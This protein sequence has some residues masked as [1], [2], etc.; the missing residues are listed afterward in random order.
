M[1]GCTNKG[2]HA[3]LNAIRTNAS[4]QTCFFYPCFFV[5]FVLK[6]TKRCN[7]SSALLGPNGEGGGPENFVLSSGKLAKRNATQFRP[8]FLQK[9]SEKAKKRFQKIGTVHVKLICWTT[10]V[11]AS[12]KWRETITC[13]K[14]KALNFLISIVTLAQNKAKKNNRDMDTSTLVR[15]N[16]LCSFL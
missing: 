1:H 4:V 15:N 7:S 16:V 5:H 13:R 14:V 3:L 8:F 11:S 6:T 12:F 9:E 10:K 2:D